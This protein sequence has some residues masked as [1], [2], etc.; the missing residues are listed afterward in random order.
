MQVPAG[1]RVVGPCPGIP[2]AGGSRAP[3]SIGGSRSYRAAHAYGLVLDPAG[4][5]RHRPRAR[6]LQPPRA[7]CR[8]PHDH[9]DDDHHPAEHVAATAD[10]PL[11]GGASRRHLRQVGTCRRSADQ[12]SGIITPATASSTSSR[13]HAGSGRERSRGRRTPPSASSSHA[14]DVT[15]TDTSLTLP[16][17]VGKLAGTYDNGRKCGSQARTSCRC[18]IWPHADATKPVRPATPCHADLDYANGELYMVAFVPKGGCRSL[19]RRGDAR[20][21]LRRRSTTTTTTTTANDDHDD[22]V[23]DAPPPRPRPATTTTTRRRTDD[24]QVGDAPR[25][26]LVDGRHRPRR[27]RGDPA[28][29]AHLR[30]PET[31]AARRRAAR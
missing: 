15:L 25:P 3:L 27:R 2:S 21:S 1:T 28:S 9:D 20:R 22:S 24:H 11:A 13:P 5:L 12:T 8:Q 10:R 30:D 29:A 16:K 18:Y 14:E 6:R 7:A 26:R 19:G 17:S 31:D 23:G 4:R